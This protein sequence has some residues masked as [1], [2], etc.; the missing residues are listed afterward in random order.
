MNGELKLSSLS[1]LEILKIVDP[2]MDNC[3]AGSNEGDH[4]KHTRDFTTRMK[5]IVTPEELHKQLSNEPR[6][7]FTT[8]VF[9]YVFRR[10]HSVG[11]VWKQFTSINNDELINQAIFKELDGRILI[12][13]CM[14]C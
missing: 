4:E 7:Y 13:H 5:S 14:I 6:A 1:D 10:S 9:L 12:D 8:R 3:L 2:I 11:V